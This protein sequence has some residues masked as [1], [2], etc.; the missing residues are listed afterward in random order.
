MNRLKKLKKQR[1]GK[2]RRKRRKWKNRGKLSWRENL[3]LNWLPR[4]LLQVKWALVNMWY[5][6]PG[7]ICTPHGDF[8]L[9][10]PLPLPFCPSRNF[11]SGSYFS[12]RDFGFWDPCPFAI[13]RDLLW[14]GG[15]GGAMDI[16]LDLLKWTE[17]STIEGVF[18]EVISM[19]VYLKLCSNY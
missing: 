12:F 2:L 9:N 17:W 18:K 6:A 1:K 15:E 10:F 4:K 19:F 8:V 3:M 16:F 5:V 13:V 11:S 7:N 14:G